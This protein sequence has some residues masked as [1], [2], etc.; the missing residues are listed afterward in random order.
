MNNPI[1]EGLEM[2]IISFCMGTY[3]EH[4]IA[5]NL[6]KQSHTIT[7]ELR[8]LLRKSLPRKFVES[9]IVAL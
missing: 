1:S 3:M 4:I 2:V 7:L 6:P 5:V 9:I 8:V